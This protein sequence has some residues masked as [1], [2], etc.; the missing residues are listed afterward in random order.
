MNNNYEFDSLDIN[1]LLKI[2]EY[3]TYGLPNGDPLK[4]FLDSSD[5][6]DAV[7][8]L[9]SIAIAENIYMIDL[10]TDNPNALDE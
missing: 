2:Q 10:E 6:D 9:N 1:L 4:D 5:I 3:V 7:V 8:L